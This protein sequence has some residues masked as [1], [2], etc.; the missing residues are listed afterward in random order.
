M[1]VIPSLS[2]LSLTALN[3]IAWISNDLLKLTLSVFSENDL[4]MVP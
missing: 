4:Q 3:W 1:M 2:S